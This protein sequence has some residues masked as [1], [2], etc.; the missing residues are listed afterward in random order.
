MKV[1]GQSRNR[2]DTTVE[3]RTR[4]KFPGYIE[5]AVEAMQPSP[6][7]EQENMNERMSQRA[8]G[9]VS[10]RVRMADLS[11]YL[12]NLSNYGE[13]PKSTCTKCWCQV[14][15]TVYLVLTENNYDPRTTSVNVYSLIGFLVLESGLLVSES[16]SVC[17]LG[18][19]C[20]SSCLLLFEN[21]ASTQSSQARP[22][23]RPNSVVLCTTMLLFS[24]LP[25]QLA[26]FL[27]V[28]HKQTK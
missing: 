6:Y 8:G 5:I 23:S 26:T 27:S 16:V 14:A 18:V 20:F 13:T 19:V 4:P 3:T 9:R 22:Q 7:G 21:H 15:I 17:G 1:R 10:A 12:P 2:F 28:H 11:A 25:K 24:D